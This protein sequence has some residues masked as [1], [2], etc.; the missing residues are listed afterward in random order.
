MLEDKITQAERKLAGK[1]IGCGG[2]LAS[3]KGRHGEF[4]ELFK[5]NCRWCALTVLE[6]KFYGIKQ[7]G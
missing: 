1:C 6:E 3:L 7:N 4:R 5:S 2:D